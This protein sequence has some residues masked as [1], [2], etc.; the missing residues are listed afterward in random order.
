MEWLSHRTGLQKENFNIFHKDICRIHEDF[1]T[2]M[3]H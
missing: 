1:L 2:V 3:S